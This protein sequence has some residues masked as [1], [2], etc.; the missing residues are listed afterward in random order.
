MPTCGLFGDCGC[1]GAGEEE[2]GTA[3]YTLIKSVYNA[4]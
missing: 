4:R 2:E 1:E 3:G